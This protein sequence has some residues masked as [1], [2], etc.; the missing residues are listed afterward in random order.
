L[1]GFFSRQAGFRVLVVPDTHNNTS[2]LREKTGI[3]TTKS[4]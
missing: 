2:M 1:L 3:L 4:T